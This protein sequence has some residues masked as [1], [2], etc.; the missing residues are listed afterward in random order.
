MPQCTFTARDHVSL[1][2]NIYTGPQPY[3]LLERTAVETGQM[4][5]PT[6]AAPP[7]QT[8]TGLGIDAYWFPDRNQL[9]STDGVRL[10]T[11]SVSWAG[12]SLARQLALA[13]ALSRMYLTVPRRSNGLAKGYPSPSG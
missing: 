10:I 9:M 4:L 2:V 5:V 1:T 6:H 13:T 3:F 12:A 8:V 7:P 11:A